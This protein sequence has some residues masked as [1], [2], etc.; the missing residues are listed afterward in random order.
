MNSF[1]ARMAAVPLSV[2][3]ERYRERWIR[4][5]DPVLLPG[6]TISGILQCLIFFVIA[7]TV[8]LND[9]PLYVVLYFSLEGLIRLVGAVATHE[10]IPTVPRVLVAW[11]QSSVYKSRERQSLPPLVRDIVETLQD[12]E[13]RVTSCRAKHDWNGVISVRY[14]DALYELA[15]EEQGSEA[16][17]FVYRLRLQPENKVVR[18]VRDYAP[19]EVLHGR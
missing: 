8:R 1:T 17:P 2:L 11:A 13:L 4:T 19:D 3:P 7:N 6:A 10:I 18:G 12:E 9:L 15:G 5:T 14:G 16:R